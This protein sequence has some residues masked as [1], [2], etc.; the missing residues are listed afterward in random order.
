MLTPSE[1]EAFMN[2]LKNPESESAKELLRSAV[3]QVKSEEPWWEIDE[4]F[5]SQAEEA[6]SGSRPEHSERNTPVLIRIP[7][8]MVKAPSPNTPFLLYNVCAVG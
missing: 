8:A 1:R 4:T 7:R 5:Q 3:Q 6:A 2:K